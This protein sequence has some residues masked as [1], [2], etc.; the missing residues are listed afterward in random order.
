MPEAD[1]IVAEYARRDASIP[2]ERYLPAAP[3]QVLVRESRERAVLSVLRR[4][5]MLPLRGRRILDVGCG[6]GQWLV[7]FETWGAERNRLAGIDLMPNRIAAARARL[8]PGADL[9][10]GD[11][12]RLPW[13][14]SCF[15]IV[16]QSTVFSSVLDTATRRT[17]AAEMARVLA[18]VGVI[19]WNDFFVNNPGNSAVR[20]VRRGEIAGLF[21][22]F[23]VELR[24]ITLA[25][26][27]A[28]AVA[29]RSQLAAIAIEALRIFNTHYLG[30][31]RRR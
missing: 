22:G 5:G 7:D 1:R 21:P 11:A 6:T 24:R 18:P 13:P 27:L 26:P 8:T 17:L 16:V 3:A 30:V 12:S 20:G 25:P 14:S 29:P 9:R 15:E 4:A 10:E 28:R 31:L 23:R 2:R 19:L